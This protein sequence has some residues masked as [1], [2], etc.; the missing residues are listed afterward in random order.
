MIT[1]N[2]KTVMI[3]D[4][5]LLSKKRLQEIMEDGGH[6]IITADNGEDMVRIIRN[7]Q[8]I[9]L[10]LMDMHLDKVDGLRM[11]EWMNLNINIKFP[12]VCMAPLVE[13]DSIFWKVKDLGAKEIISKNL[14]PELILESVNSILFSHSQKSRNN[15][16]KF[17]TIPAKFNLGMTDHE[18]NILNISP[19]GMFLHTD[20]TLLT[21]S[22][23]KV[24]F[25]LPNKDKTHITTTGTVKWI[26]PKTKRQSLF[27]GVGIECQYPREINKRQL[28]TF[29]A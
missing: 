2:T 27:S 26:T 18:A 14:T 10:L 28:E 8:K 9:D 29:F 17:A 13:I 11:L 3:A 7:K 25:T 5:N 22:R 15:K 4:S 24:D 19:K 6:R 16:R 12:I 23:V 20:M 1:K 21:G